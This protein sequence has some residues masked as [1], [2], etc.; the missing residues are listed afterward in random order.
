MSDS[1]PALRS[2][3][4]VISVIHYLNHPK[5]HPPLINAVNEVR[6]EIGL[7]DQEW[8]SQ[9]NYN[10][11]GQD[12]WDQWIRDHLLNIGSRSRDWVSNWVTRIRNIWAVRTGQD[13]LYIIRSRCYGQAQ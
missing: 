11:R 2:I 4:S 13:A 1:L 8:I 7:A 5:V 10:P 9:G 6:T 3:R 12:W